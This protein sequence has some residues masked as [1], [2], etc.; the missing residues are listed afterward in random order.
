MG[1]NRN[2]STDSRSFGPIKK[3]KIVGRAILRIWPVDR[4]GFL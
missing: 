1:D 4:L 3:S 2:R